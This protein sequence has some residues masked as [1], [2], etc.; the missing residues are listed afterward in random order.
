MFHTL[1]YFSCDGTMPLTPKPF[2]QIY[3]LHGVHADLPERMESSLIAY[4]LLPGKEEQHYLQFFNV[5]SLKVQQEFG[6]I[7]GA[8]TFVFDHELGAINAA[9]QIFNRPNDK[10]I[11]CYFHYSQNLVK[12]ANELGLKAFWDEPELRKFIRHL[13]G[14]VFLPEELCAVV[15]THTLNNP[16]RLNGNRRFND[17]ID[18]FVNYFQFWQNVGII[19]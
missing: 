14:G 17:A 1:R 11:S 8:K 10:F 12:K 18:S 6:D 13:Q 5:L 9:K 7:G 2:Y 15:W 19:I 4:A 3:S 16:P